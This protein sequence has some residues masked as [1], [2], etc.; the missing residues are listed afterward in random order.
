MA[1]IQCG[2]VQFQQIQAI[3]FD[4]DGTLADSHAYLSHL[5]HKRARLLDAQVPGVQEPLLMAFGLDRD[6]L[7]PAGLLAVGTR[8]ENEV[9]AAA[10]VA[11]TGRNWLES[12][13]IVR[14]AFM[15]ADQ[16]LQRK[17]DSTP[18]F[19]GAIDLLRSL[20]AAGIKLGILSADTTTNVQD[21]IDRYQLESLIQV[22]MGTD[23]P[24]GKPHP[25]PFHRICEA[26]ATPPART[27]MVGDS[28]ADLE[29]AQAAGAAGSVGVTWGWTGVA[30]LTQATVIIH[31]FTEIYLLNHPVKRAEE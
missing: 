8:Q 6:V 27:L 14:S 26:L 11:E 1:T 4:K 19:A 12:L 13:T 25:A 23:L 31:Q 15:E 9:A 28:V 30:A 29:M 22:G 21:F 5:G 24:P 16:I 3:V 7:N 17:A 10:Y 18:P 20:A 2:A